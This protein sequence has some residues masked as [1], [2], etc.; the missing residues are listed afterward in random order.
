MSGFQIPEYALYWSTMSNAHSKTIQ[1][2]A[3]IDHLLY[4]WQA[5][6]DLQIYQ[7]PRVGGGEG[8]G[9]RREGGRGE[10]RREK[11]GKEEGKG[12]REEEGEGE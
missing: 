9:G 12:E 5:L 8:E 10:E 11:G 2:V 7:K 3:P 1:R 6:I 4:Y